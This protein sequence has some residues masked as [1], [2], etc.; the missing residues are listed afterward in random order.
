MLALRLFARFG[1]VPTML[2]GLNLLAVYVVAGGYSIIWIGALLAVA[3][4]LSLL[5]ERALPFEQSW[6]TALSDVPKDVAHGIVYE[7][8][9]I[10]AIL[11]LPLVTTVIPWAG[12]WP[13]TLPLG[14][15]LLL[16]ILIADFSMT[17]IHY[18]S[19]R[20]T[21]LWKL[22]SIHHGVHRL[23]SFNGLLRHPMHQLMDLA[24]GTLPLVLAGL[25]VKVAIL[26]AFA[27]SVQLLVQHSNTDFA[28]GPFQRL[29]AVGEVHRLH[30]VNWVGQGDVNFGLFFTFWDGLFG[31]LRFVTGRA[32]RAGDIGI[33]D[34]PGFPQ[35][36]LTQ[37]GLP[38]T[39]YRVATT[40]EQRPA[41]SG[42]PKMLTEM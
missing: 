6:N 11:M 41:S 4:A 24:V 1:Y 8:S 28:L 7:L 35:H 23:Y 13:T 32:P 39:N 15:Q 25:P 16:A 30:H 27:V 9:N 2:G 21:W 12:I 3:V 37:L 42:S 10:T 31:T 18:L 22:H 26:L 5:S 34:D 33:Q 17:M 40:D 20:M 36:Y 19:H 14:V 29:L 38:F